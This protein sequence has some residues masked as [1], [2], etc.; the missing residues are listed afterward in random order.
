MNSGLDKVFKATL[1]VFCL[2]GPKVRVLIL[3][4][5]CLPHVAYFLG[6]TAGKA[7]RY[8]Y[9]GEHVQVIS[10]QVFT[11]RDEFLPITAEGLATHVLS[12]EWILT[13]R[14]SKWEVVP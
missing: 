14:T 10:Q 7:H 3:N 2:R 5:S 4:G 12:S 6:T 8:Y 1:H 9:L 13:L 11:K